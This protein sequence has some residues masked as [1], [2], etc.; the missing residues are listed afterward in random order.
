MCP[1][2]YADL[3]VNG[4]HNNQG[5]SA[6][7]GEACQTGGRVDHV[8]VKGRCGAKIAELTS[9]TEERG[10]VEPPFLLIFNFQVWLPLLSTN[11]QFC[12]Y[13][14]LYGF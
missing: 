4:N 2:V 10:G 11:Q 6:G 8:A 5:V 9:T 1:L 13:F 7:S 12:S 3:F 14:F